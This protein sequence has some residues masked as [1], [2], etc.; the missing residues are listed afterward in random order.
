MKIAMLMTVWKAAVRLAA[1]ALVC[2]AIASAQ[3]KC[4]ASADAR[5]LRYYGA[6]E[7]LGDLVIDC[8][9]GSSDDKYQ[10][11]VSTDA[12]LT[13]RTLS[14]NDSLSVQWTEALLLVDDPSPQQQKVCA[15]DAKLEA[16]E[17]GVVDCGPNEGKANVFQGLRLQGNAVVFR[18]TPLAAPKPTGKRR[19]RIVNLRVDVRDL[20]P[21]PA[22]EPDPEDVYGAPPTPSAA[23]PEEEVRLTVSIYGPGGQSIPV[24]HYEQLAG[25]LA[26]GVKFDVR[27]AANES[28]P[29]TEPA[30]LTTPGLTPQVYPEDGPTFLVQFSELSPN[31]FRRR[32]VGT[33]GTDPIFVT[34]QAYPGID[35]N[36]ESGIF[37]AAYP[38][39]R[40]LNKAGLSDSGVRLRVTFD[41]IPPGVRVW[42]SYRDVETG[43]SGFDPEAPRARLIVPE[44]GVFLRK[45]P[46]KGIFVEVPPSNGHA[47]ILWEVTL[48]DPTVIETLSFSIGMTGPNRDVEFG[49]AVVFGDIAPE[50]V[51]P[52]NEFAVAAEVIPSF[53]MSGKIIEPRAAFS[54]VPA[55]DMS[56]FTAVSAASYAS[57]VIAPASI[58]AGFGEALAPEIA[59]VPSEPQVVLGSTRVNVVDSSGALRPAMIFAA[60]PMQINMYLDA[61]TRIGPAVVTVYDGARPVAEG[62]IQVGNLSPGLFSANGSG[63]GAAA[64][65]LVLV[66]GTETDREILAEYGEDIGAVAPRELDFSGADSAY[67]VLYGTGIRRRSDLSN[68]RLTIGGIEVPVIYA[69]E[70]LEYLGL[71]QLNAGPL[72]LELAGRGLVDVKLTV[73]GI[74]SNTVQARFR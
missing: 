16:E 46:E 34:S 64:G 68:T 35:T 62:L 13:S 60:G 55:L 24:E 36:T 50:F 74:T 1:L 59:P 19:L 61:A 57:G 14:A 70:Q 47:E 45:L 6:A 58:I 54:V 69:G 43:T 4:S 17:P 11:I 25:V 21:V 5:T 65:E 31:V 7:L 26:P 63:Q 15:P 38:R 42:A 18:D 27:T 67:L 51:E 3:M 29:A 44:S 72:P 66:S 37:N 23:D 39:V 52:E 48:S 10:I 22:K 73:D 71:D 53:D 32:N 30:L 12:P 56:E 49:D 33:N 28:V 40:G 2:A 41:D 20:T 8:V 9:G